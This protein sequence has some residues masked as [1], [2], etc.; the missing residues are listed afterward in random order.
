[1]KRGALV[2]AIYALSILGVSVF[3]RNHHPAGAELYGLALL[4]T[5]SIVL[6][7]V[8]IARYLRE[9]HDG[10]HRDMLVRCLLWGTG[11]VLVTAV[12]TGFLR[13]LGWKG[14]L[15]PFTELFVFV[16]FMAAAKLAYKLQNRVLKDE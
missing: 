6:M 10:F 16:G 5:L 14:Q 7:M 4:P 3:L 8:S 12:F 15:P 9:E 13:S 1:M 2:F 11:A